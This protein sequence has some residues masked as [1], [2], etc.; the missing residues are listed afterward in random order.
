MWKLE[1]S[2]RGVELFV[3]GEKMQETKGSDDVD[4]TVEM[5]DRLRVAKY[6]Q[7][8]KLAVKFGSVTE[9]FVTTFEEVLG[10]VESE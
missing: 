10:D 3:I 6:I 5:I 8:D 4:G 7:G 1:Q 9:Q 2:L